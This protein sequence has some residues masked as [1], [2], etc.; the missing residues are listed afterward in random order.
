MEIIRRRGTLVHLIYGIRDIYNKLIDFRRNISFLGLINS[1]LHLKL[2]KNLKSVDILYLCHDNSRP[3]LIDGKYCSPLIDSINYQLKNYSNYTVA[4]PFSRYSG[5]KCYG[6]T[7]N[8]N[9]YVFSSVLKRFLISGSIKLLNPEKDPLID[10]YSLLILKTNPKLIIG[11]QPSIEICIAARNIGVRIVDV[12]HGIISTSDINSYYSP[13]KRFYFENQGWPDF[14]FCRNKQTLSEVQKIK[15]FSRGVLIGN[16]NKFFHE[17]INP[18]PTQK[19][20]FLNK[21]KTILVTLQ[22]FYE[23]ISYSRSNLHNGIIFPTV[24]LNKIFSSKYN[25]IL[26]LHPSQILNKSLYAKY[27]S[28]F[29]TMFS[30]RENVDY[31]KN[32]SLP[33]EVSLSQSDLHI[34]FNSAS[35]FDAYDFGLKTILLDENIVRL[36]NYFGELIDTDLVHVD[37]VSEINLDNLFNQVNSLQQSYYFDFEKFLLRDR[38]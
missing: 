33:L 2:I 6:N 20:Y 14:I 22:P 26:R 15:K 25:F 4:L 3:F 1:V 36:R 37:S 7:I 5:S 34:T 18:N 8:L 21:K 28:A 10:F 31:V 9:L 11:I 38:V 24:V 13:Q 17:N 19:K 23:S 32:N 30:D 12:Q 27:I 16:L 29:N 35:L